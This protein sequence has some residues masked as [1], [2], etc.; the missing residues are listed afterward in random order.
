MLH[1]IIN[2]ICVLYILL[3]IFFQID[4]GTQ[5]HVDKTSDTVN[6]HK[7]YDIINV[8]VLCIR[9]ICA[10]TQSDCLRTTKKKE[11][12]EIVDCDALGIVYLYYVII[13]CFTFNGLKTCFQWKI[14]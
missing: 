9:T 12:I 2:I 11:N 8:T 13:D 5:S 7:R 6:R 4:F 10:P 1:A 14:F 3:D